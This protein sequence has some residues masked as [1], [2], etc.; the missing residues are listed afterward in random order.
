MAKAHIDSPSF[1]RF[2]IITSESAASTRHQQRLLRVV[3]I[4]CVSACATGEG[5]ST[6]FRRPVVCNKHAGARRGMGMGMTWTG[7]EHEAVTVG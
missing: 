4:T 1:L 2:V 6:K 3:D 5:E 7:R